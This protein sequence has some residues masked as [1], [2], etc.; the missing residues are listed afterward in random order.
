MA[1]FTL[2]FTLLNS[3]RKA[4]AL[5]DDAVH[6]F[7]CSFVCLSPETLGAA[8]GRRWASRTKGVADVSSP[9]KNF[10]PREIYACGGGLLVA[11]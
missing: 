11:P 4:G 2:L 8:G 6:L 10:I 9:L 5:R 3:E 7:V 1:A